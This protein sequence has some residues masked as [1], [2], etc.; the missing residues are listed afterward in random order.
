VKNFRST[1]EQ[2]EPRE[3]AV[4]IETLLF[5]WIG[6]GLTSPA[7]QRALEVTACSAADHEIEVRDLVSVR[8]L[9]KT[10]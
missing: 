4:L 5:H 3:C 2:I 6:G 8:A 1:R 10:I 9:A 7:F